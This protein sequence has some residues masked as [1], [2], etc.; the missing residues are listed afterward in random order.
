MIN[1]PIKGEGDGA[2]ESWQMGELHDR[3]YLFLS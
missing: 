2:R 1:K 3:K